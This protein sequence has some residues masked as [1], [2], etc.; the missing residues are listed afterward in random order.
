MTLLRHKEDATGMAGQDLENQS[1]CLPALAPSRDPNAPWDKRTSPVNRTRNLMLLLS[2]PVILLWLS[3]WSCLNSPYINLQLFHFSEFWWVFDLCIFVSFLVCGGDVLY[4]S[5]ESA[6][7][8]ICFYTFVTIY[9]VLCVF[10]SPYQ[11]ELVCFYV[12]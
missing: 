3:C 1:R 7:V 9:S 10:T 5:V 12:I 4:D 11:H 2:R 8:F 6:A